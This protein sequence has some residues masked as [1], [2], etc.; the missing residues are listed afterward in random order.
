MSMPT[1][2]QAIKAISNLIDLQKSETAPQA[3]DYAKVAISYIQQA[4]SLKNE[5]IDVLE[6][7]A[8]S[9]RIVGDGPTEETCN[10]V[11]WKVKGEQM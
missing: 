7:V 11:I 10:I 4:E 6:Q 3:A 2:S 5:M 8:E 9:S 1:K